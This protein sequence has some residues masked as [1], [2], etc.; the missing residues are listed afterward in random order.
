MAMQ[1]NTTQ[2]PH[3][4]IR[5]WMPRLKDVELRVL[6]VV[7]DQTLGWIEDAAT[8]KRKEKDWISHYQ[9]RTKTGRSDRAVSGAVKTL[10]ETHHIVE[11]YDTAGNLLNTADKRRRVGYRI[12]YRL[13][14]LRPPASLF[15]TPAKSAVVKI[16][17]EP[18]QNLRTQNLRTTKETVITKENTLQPQKPVALENSKKPSKPTSPHKQFVDFWHRNVQRSRGI[19]PVITGADGRNLKRILDAGIQPDSLEQAA[20]YFL[21]D[22][23]FRTFSPSL[24]TFLSAGVINGLLNRIKNEPEFWKKIDSYAA[25]QGGIADNPA[26]ISQAV[27]NLH[28]LRDGLAGRFRM[29]ATT[30]YE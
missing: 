30:T 22:R 13:N 19:K 16:K 1:P 27:K 5:E 6:L 28:A 23:S 17:K 4:I 8:G 18:P 3:I 9:L 26:A 20:V 14:L 7:T 2:I 10:I 15:D 12:Y 29:P 24:S 25:R 11:A 21:H